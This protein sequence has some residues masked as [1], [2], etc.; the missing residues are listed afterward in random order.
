ML[1]IDR[2]LS[3]DTRCRVEG[4]YKWY[5]NFPMNVNEPQLFVIDEMFYN[6]FLHYHPNVNDNGRARS[7][8]IEVTLQKKLKK[9]IYGLLGATWFHSQ[10]RDL[11][12]VWRNRVF[13]SRIIMSAESGY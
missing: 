7:Y 4:Y 9:G 5:F 13:D 2:L 8:G 12:G 11:L 10:Y 3:D 1:G 6:E